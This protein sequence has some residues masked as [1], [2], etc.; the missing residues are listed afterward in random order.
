M[1]GQTQLEIQQCLNTSS[2]QYLKRTGAIFEE[3]NSQMDN[4]RSG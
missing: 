3:P 1:R 2:S 4:Q